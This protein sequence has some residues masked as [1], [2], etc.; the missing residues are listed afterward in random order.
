MKATL[1]CGI[2][3]VL[4]VWLTVA[5]VCSEENNTPVE[6]RT[7]HIDASR[8]WWA[9]PQP[10]ISFGSASKKPPSKTIVKS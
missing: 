5:V 3:F 1:F 7:G 10:D 6:Q 2:F 8:D 4:A 9:K